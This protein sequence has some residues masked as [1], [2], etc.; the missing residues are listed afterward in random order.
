MSARVMASS[1]R[2]SG[3][4]AGFMSAPA[5]LAGAPLMRLV[6]AARADVAPTLR[7]VTPSGFIARPSP[8]DVP[9]LSFPFLGAWFLS[10][11]AETTNASK[12]GKET[13]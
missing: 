2:C 12:E 10:F 3:S 6:R 13:T 4:V 5:R 7:V 11:S 9:S 1:V 8:T